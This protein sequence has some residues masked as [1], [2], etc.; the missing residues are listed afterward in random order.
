MNRTWKLLCLPALLTLALTA[1]SVRAKDS[2][3]KTDDIK[4][5]L[6]IVRQMQEENARLRADFARQQDDIERRQ[7]LNDQRD[8]M[9]EKRLRILESKVDDLQR[10]GKG[11]VS[12][13]PTEQ[14]A[15][16][17]DQLRDLDARIRRL[18]RERLSGSFT[19][20][21]TIT[22]PA[23]PVVA[24]GAVRI[25]N[26]SLNTSIIRI[27]GVTYTV[28]PGEAVAATVPSGT[29]T[30]EVLADA[31]GFRYAPQVRTVPANGEFTLFVNP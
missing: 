23:V 18:E 26:L 10:P 21:D 24:T 17:F 15:P 3:A 22:P 31:R 29:F 20:S 19:P 8:E 25:Q 28:R 7:R 6:K 4:E 2:D 9:F 13:Y 27:N 12:N 14:A 16:S 11:R 5:I 1:S 30:Y